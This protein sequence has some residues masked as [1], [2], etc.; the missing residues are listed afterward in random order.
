[1]PT[2]CRRARA[3]P[4]TRDGEFGSHRAETRPLAPSCRC[5]DVCFRPE[6]VVLRADPW[7]PDY[8][9]GFDVAVEESPPPLADPFVETQDWSRP[10]SPPPAAEKPM[11]FV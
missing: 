11:W 7:M 4:S 5:P 10:V 2:R 6:M 8:G 1:M 9:M 3:R